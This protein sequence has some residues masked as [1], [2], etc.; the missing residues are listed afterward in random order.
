MSIQLVSFMFYILTHYLCI[1][2]QI[3]QKN[4]DL[5]KSFGTSNSS[6][7]KENKFLNV[8]RCSRI[9]CLIFFNMYTGITAEKLEWG[10]SDQLNQ[11]LGSHLGGFDLILGADIYILMIFF[12]HTSNAGMCVSMIYSTVILILFCCLLYT[13]YCNLCI[14]A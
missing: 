8:M 5:H 13:S 12:Y 1:P 10:D 14:L 2:F 3:L 4:I 11:I 6:N 9:S 7:C